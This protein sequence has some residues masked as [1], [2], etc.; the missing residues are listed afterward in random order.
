MLVLAFGTDSAAR[1]RPSMEYG[2]KRAMT[3]MKTS[4]IAEPNWTTALA[5]LVCVLAGGC[6]S[7]WGNAAP[8]IEFT[9]IPP[10]ARGGR[11]RVDVI[12]GRVKGARPGQQ[13][14]I[15]SEEHTSEL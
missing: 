6:H 8:V 12:A 13:I 10:S 7:Q 4:K 9:K 2:A 1:K 15:R 11:E 3:K 14:V 5:L